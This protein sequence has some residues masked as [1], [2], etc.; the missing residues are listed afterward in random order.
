MMSWPR[1]KG[2][3]FDRR[4][5]L[6]DVALILA[7]AVFEERRHTIVAAGLFF[8]WLIT[9]SLRRANDREQAPDPRRSHGSQSFR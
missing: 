3:I 6:F 5:S 9:T 4:L 7:A 1:L 2:W 8:V